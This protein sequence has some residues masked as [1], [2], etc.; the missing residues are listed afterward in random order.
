VAR[1]FRLTAVGVATTVAVTVL[2]AACSSSPASSG[3]GAA[4]TAVG[5]GSNGLNPGTPTYGGTLNEIGVSDVAFMD[6]DTAYYSTDDNVMRLTVRGLYAWG[7]T[8]STAT[9]PEPDLATGPPQVSA[10]GL[11]VTVT[12]RSGVM[13]NTSPAREVTAADAARGLKRACNPSPV[14][15]GGMAD[16]ESTIVGLTAFCQGYPKAAGTDA[17]VMKK[18][19]DSTNVPGIIA[20][21]QTL[22]L[23]LTQPAAWLEGAM[24]L[25]AFNPTPIEAEN[26]LP[27]TPGVYNHM[28]S[29][30]PYEIASYSP[31]K[32]IDFV[33]N[34]VWKA[35]T[36]P[37]RKAYVNEVKVDETGNQK[38]IYQQITTNSAALGLTWDSLPPPA[39]TINLL[40]QIKS[41]SPDVSLS[42]TFGSNP[43]LVFN[44]ISP[45]NGG[46]LGQVS[47]RQAL[48][49]GLDRSQMTKTLGGE[50]VNPPLTHVLPPGTDG[51]QDVPS[52]YNPYPYD[53]SKAKSMLAAAG[54]TSS[55]PLTIKFL[56]RSD[57]QG[58]TLLFENIQAQL[59]SLGSVSVTGVPTNQSDFYAKYLQA[60]TPPTPA[61]KGVWD[62]TGAGWSPDWYGNGT[63]TWFNPLFSSPGGHPAN[64]GSNFG[65]FSSTTVNS[66]IKTA[67]AQQ[68]EPEA[69]VYWAKADEAV[70]QA[71]AIYPITAKN[72]LAAHASYVHNA[73]YLPIMQQYD[74][75]NVWLSSS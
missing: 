54:F 28:Y 37:L 7:N 13:W 26:A 56:Y 19:I 49:Y 21:G 23:K 14:Y 71:A 75:A 51:S 72:Q 57:S 69:D 65:Y 16:F 63:L 39:D 31:K 38:T 36:D 24:T 64:G 44:T 8:P 52:D 11:T 55:H 17:A 50:E 62:M 58:Q 33:R 47:V 73:V 25:A 48:S 30:G 46:A 29:D 60:T 6:Y 41:D 42:Q 67:L 34:P 4:P 70:M 22:T 32:S 43:Y 27:G 2:A 61:A 10:N 1:H 18:Y 12:L 20:N 15:F 35:S 5:T 59:D 45:N 66:L 53:P 9:T 68:T 40:N 3:T 74:A